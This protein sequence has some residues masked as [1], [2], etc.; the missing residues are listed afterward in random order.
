MCDYKYV[1][2]RVLSE[3]TRVLVMQTCIHQHIY[4]YTTIHT[5]THIHVHK[6]TNTH[7]HTQTHIHVHKHTITHTH[8]VLSFEMVAK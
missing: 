7:T 2:Q 5:L 3:N 6:H 1:Q 4:M 8:T